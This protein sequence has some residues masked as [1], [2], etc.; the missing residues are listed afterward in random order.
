MSTPLTREPELD[1]IKLSKPLA[2]PQPPRGVSSVPIDPDIRRLALSCLLLSYVGPVTPPWIGA[3][4][5]EGLGGVV[6]FGSNL[7]D[8]TQVR[9]LT[10]R[11]RAA[12][13]RDVVLA[14]DEE[15]GDV[16]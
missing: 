10:D 6:L 1:T 3:A 14:L 5:G 4:L 9:E 15:G 2:S 8:G 12:A 7:G 13:G 16:T 11:L